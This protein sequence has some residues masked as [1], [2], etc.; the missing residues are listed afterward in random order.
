MSDEAAQLV[1][2]S[3]QGWGSRNFTRLHPGSA[4]VVR[5]GWLSTIQGL[6]PDELG[7]EALQA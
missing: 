2:A 1:R 6:G 4:V 5:T 7:L 3:P